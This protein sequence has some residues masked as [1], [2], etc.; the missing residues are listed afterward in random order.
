M[1][2]LDLS[3]PIRKA[4]FSALDDLSFQ[5]VQIPIFDE[6]LNGDS[7]I[8]SH[9]G[10]SAECYVV[11]QSQVESNHPVPTFCNQRMN[12][13][14]SVRIVTKYNSEGNKML[15]E[16]IANQVLNA[17]I[18]DRYGGHKLTS[19]EISIESVKF[20]TS[21]TLTEIAGN[22]SAFSRILTFNNIV[23]D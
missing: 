22:E 8:I 6:I 1:A 17:I 2:V 9:Y 5:G 23:N 10:Q 19:S 12:C 18:T 3:L 11:L 13:M 7:A 21:N 16:L 20:D 4:Y 15:S 14:I